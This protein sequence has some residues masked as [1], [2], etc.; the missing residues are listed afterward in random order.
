MIELLTPTQI[1]EMRPAGR[2]VADVLTQVSAAA[3]VGVDLLELDALA[4]QMIRDRAP[5]PATS[6]TTPRSEPCP[7]ARS[8][9]PR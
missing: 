3:D 1:D 8:S 6:T 7:S 5:S 2:F 4:H 9:A